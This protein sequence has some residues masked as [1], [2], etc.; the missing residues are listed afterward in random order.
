MNHRSLV[1]R[2]LLIA[3]AC[4][5]VIAASIALDAASSTNTHR[6]QR[7][8]LACSGIGYLPKPSAGS[9]EAIAMPRSTLSALATSGNESLENVVGAFDK[10]AREQNS[11]AMIEALDEGVNVCHRLHLPTASTQ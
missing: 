3:T 11:D 10:A 2:G 1:L 4:V 9:F 6:L 8:A 7:E 5:V